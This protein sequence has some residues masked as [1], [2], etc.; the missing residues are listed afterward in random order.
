[1][2]LVVFLRGVNVGG[3]RTF[4]PSVVA[5]ELAE[6]G[7]VNIGAAGTFV[8]R[9]PGS[10]ARFRA[11]LAEQLPFETSI[12]ICDGRAI[13]DLERDSPFGDAPPA[14]GLT[15]FVRVLEKA[16]KSSETLPLV[17]PAEG[18]WLV[19]LIG[20][21]GQFVFGEYRRDMKT[22]RY[23]DQLDKLFGGKATTRNWNTIL[24]IARELRSSS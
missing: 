20:A 15:R 19:R 7:V 2:A 4:R 5:K 17:L 24:A 14:A 12:A 8:V 1:M 10:R 16:A 11:A 21:S 18:D 13:L 3:H 9:K 6:F 22:I 23:L